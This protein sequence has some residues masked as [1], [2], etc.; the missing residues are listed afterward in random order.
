[1]TKAATLCKA[2]PFHEG[3]K[4]VIDVAVALHD[5]VV[6]IV[7]NDTTEK[8][9]LS[10]RHIMEHYADN[11]KITVI[12]VVD[13]QINEIEYDEEGTAINCEEYWDLWTDLLEELH[14][15]V[16]VT[17]DV[18]GRELAKRLGIKWLPV[19][20]ERHTVPTSATQV[21]QSLTFDWS[22]NKNNSRVLPTSNSRAW[23]YI[24]PEAKKDWGTRIAI[25]GPESTGKSVMSK[26]LQKELPTHIKSIPEWGRTISV[27]RDNELTLKD[28]ED[29]II[30]Q[31]IMMAAAQA[32][33]PIVVTDTEAMITHL[34]AQDF[35]SDKDQD[36]F[37]KHIAKH[38]KD[39]S[40]DGYIVLAPSVPWVDD[41]S[42]IQDTTKSRTLF[43]GRIIALL[44]KY[45]QVPV[46]FIESEDWEVRQRQAINFTLNV[47]MEKTKKLV[48]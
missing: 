13:T 18:Y 11:R 47:A 34:F 45:T 30:V 24:M 23:E 16:I 43:Y 36:T 8:V 38:I 41:G 37:A 20:P 33:A 9:D 10:R 4:L 40:I 31:N 12:P 2:Y 28:F 26:Y 14:V 39:N 27:E 29:I 15:D 19:D 6:V 21:K 48:N 46:I 42:R 7:S 22:S 35:L 44:K 5:E 1:M 3:H 17:S 32:K 25:V